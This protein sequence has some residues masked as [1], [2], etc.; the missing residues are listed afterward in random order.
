ME[1]S[2]GQNLCDTNIC[3]SPYATKVTPDRRGSS[4]PRGLRFW[5]DGV[6]ERSS[7]DTFFGPK[8][9]SPPPRDGHSENCAFT[10]ENMCLT[11][12]KLG[13]K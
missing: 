4:T 10:V 13:I 8:L 9:V 12:N 5:M 1:K 7:V 2:L 11:N 3:T 6:K